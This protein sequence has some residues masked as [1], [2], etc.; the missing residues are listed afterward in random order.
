MFTARYAQSPY[1]KE[2]QNSTLYV[3][4]HKNTKKPHSD[5]RIVKL[6][7]TGPRTTGSNPL[8]SLHRKG[9][10]SRHDVIKM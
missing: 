10:I 2:T 8:V 1:I 9:G 7:R 4:N 3:K 6:L 5:V